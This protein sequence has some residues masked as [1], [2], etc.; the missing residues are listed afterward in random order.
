MML[1]SIAL[2]GFRCFGP[3]VIIGPFDERMTVIHG[4]NG[5]GKS[6]LLLA[7]ERTLFDRPDSA[8]TE[9]Q[10]LV[11]WGADVLPRVE[12]EL[13]TPEGTFRLSKAFGRRGE[14][15]LWKLEGG[16][17]S[18]IREG[19]SAVD[20]A[21]EILGGQAP[22]R[23][24]TKPEHRGL[25]QVLFVAQGDVALPDRLGVGAGERLRAVVGGTA[26][27]PVTRAIGDE[28]DR[29]HAA[30]FTT[31]GKPRKGSDLQT[32][33]EQAECAQQEL[34][35]ASAGWEQIDGLEDS[36]A[37]AADA[38]SASER[39][40]DGLLADKQRIAPLVKRYQEL[41]RQRDD[42]QQ[43]HDA[44]EAA[45][46]GIAE[47]IDR[48]T[49]LRKRQGDLDAT[50]RSAASATASARQAQAD[51]RRVAE[52]AT[53]RRQE[54]EEREVAVREAEGLAVRARQFDEAS[55]EIANL[56]PKLKR[57]TDLRGE[58]DRLKEQA[59]QMPVLSGRN[60]KQLRDALGEE[61]SAVEALD[62]L[63][64][65]VTVRALKKT[66]VEVGGKATPLEAGATRKL[67][68][69]GSMTLQIGAVAEVAIAGPVTDVAGARDRLMKAKA[70]AD[71]L[72][73]KL[74]S[75]A[76]EELEERKARRSDIDKALAE[77]NASLAE[78]LGEGAADETIEEQ[79]SS[80]RGKREEIVRLH[81]KWAATPPDPD[82]LAGAATTTRQAFDGAARRLRREEEAARTAAER[83][84]Q[85]VEQARDA[86]GQVRV[87]MEGVVG[88][89]RATAGDALTDEERERKRME[90]SVAFQSAKDT[91]AVAA[92]ALGEFPEDPMAEQERIE[93]A[94]QKIQDDLPGKSEEL[95]RRH[96]ALE[97]ALAAAPYARL[98]TCEEKAAE[99]D[100]SL[101]RAHLDAD[102]IDLLHT[103][104]AEEHA[105]AT[106]LLFQ[107]VADRVV[108]R[109]R[110]LVGAGVNAVE[111]DEQFRPAGVRLR[112]V[113]TA[114][115][116]DDLSYGTRD[117]LSLL[118]R[119]ALGE[120]V[121]GAGRLP[122]VLDDP[123]AH[124]DASR[125]R[126]F[127]GILEEAAAHLQVIVL[128]CRPDDY[129]ALAFGKFLDI[130][131]PGE[132]A[133]AGTGS[134]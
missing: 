127:V 48:I 76:P 95:G 120:I 105:R 85:A 16:T 133:A 104:F 59:A 2:E 7:I 24:A 49:E 52:E 113:E 64:L 111:F 36:V 46:R 47:R 100:R 22:G 69:E 112:G 115:A 130:E 1:R 129:R 72:A 18:P 23:G 131:R 26:V 80:A 119:I 107:P 81:P 70:A 98:A 10:A 126:R 71:S 110:K 40:R 17:A 63:R 5:A 3:K 60:I 125:L 34:T 117:Q 44:A 42:A 50:L 106:A 13:S 65:H 83:A 4:P 82:E 29:Q 96:Q 128:T 41:V 11:P 109:L 79:L 134:P 54:H 118:V 35:A 43:A 91:L 86:E 101:A 15:R 94:L 58:I 38:V 123:L 14:A 56:E 32:L 67:A 19:G 37:R 103:L 92:A 39:K 78:L 28:V 90:H 20:W 21:R 132:P 114:V 88:E 121:A 30:I 9:I 66:S 77:R 87:G 25:G 108:P 74:G 93:R 73:A 27:D 45:F 102:A 31:G 53:R 51:A 75:R 124:A 116:P 89:L 33:G 99:L 8:D 122:I 57:I 62:A 55:S 84:N 97:G 12:I 61:R 6:T 68:A